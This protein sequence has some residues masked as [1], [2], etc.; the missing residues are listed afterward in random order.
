[1]L[2]QERRSPTCQ[3]EM[4]K[5]QYKTRKRVEEQEEKKKGESAGEMALVQAT[6]GTAFAPTA[7]KRQPINR[8][9][10]VTSRSALSAIPL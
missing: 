6:W 4:E 2:Y 10:R 5:G 7:V 8:V 1:M 9:P 3:E